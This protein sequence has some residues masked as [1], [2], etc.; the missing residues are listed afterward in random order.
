MSKVYKFIIKVTDI[1]VKSISEGKLMNYVD[2]TSD[3]L[4]ILDPYGNSGY[5]L[6]VKSTS[7]LL[8]RQE[9]IKTLKAMGF[10]GFLK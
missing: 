5:Q 8:A 3:R 6:E 4:G 9:V 2:D 1:T 7:V 10:K